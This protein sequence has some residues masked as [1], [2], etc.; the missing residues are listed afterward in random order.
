MSIAKELL[1]KLESI[2][3]ESVKTHVDYRGERLEAGDKH[4]VFSYA[5]WS[6]LFEKYYKHVNTQLTVKNNQYTETLK[7]GTVVSEFDANTSKGYI[8]VTQ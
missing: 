3:T 1:E 5:D 7:D 2:K 4:I 8:I 6:F